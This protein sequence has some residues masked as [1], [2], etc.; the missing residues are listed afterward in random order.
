M[1]LFPMTSGLP[2]STNGISRRSALRYAGAGVAGVSLSALLVACGGGSSSNE[3][4]DADTPQMSPSASARTDFSGEVTFDNY[5][6]KGNFVPATESAPA[7]NV[8]FPKRPA[9]ASENSVQGLY[10][11]IAFV[12]AAINYLV[13]TG[14]AAPLRESKADEK[15][16]AS[17]SSFMDESNE[18]SQNRD[19]YVSPKV[20]MSAFTAV[21][22]LVKKSVQWTFDLVIDL[23]PT[24]VIDGAPAE[25]SEKVRRTERGLVITGVRHDNDWTLTIQDEYEV[26]ASAQ[27]KNGGANGGNAGNSGNSGN[28]GNSNG[29]NL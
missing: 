14:D 29:D 12:Y 25:M 2:S 23:G 27:P 6:K 28:G 24:V 4:V 21:P 9:S 16:V 18:S 5:E 20:T 17:F 19:W 10:D 22:A 8:P 11:S 3:T 26:Q 15:F 13:L 1:A 7:Q